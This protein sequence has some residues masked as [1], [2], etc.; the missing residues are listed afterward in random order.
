[1]RDDA[2]QDLRVYR[3][4]L[5]TRQGLVIHRDLLPTVLDALATRGRYVIGMSSRENRG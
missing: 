2:T 5:P 3:G 4:G 1:M